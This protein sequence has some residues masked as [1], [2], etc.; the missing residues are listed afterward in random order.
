V[1]EF[2]KTLNAIGFDIAE[3][4]VKACR[5][6]RDPSRGIPHTDI[7]NAKYA[8]YTSAPK[9]L[10]E[11]DSIMVTVP[12]PV[13][14]AHIPNFTYLIAASKSLGRNLKPG[15]KIIFESTVYPGTTEE[16]CIPVIEQESGRKWQRDFCVGYSPERINPGDREY[17]LTKIL[18]LV[19]GDT[20]ETLS[21]VAHLYERIAEPGVYRASSIKIAEDTKV[22]KIYSG[23]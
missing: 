9:L 6:G 18:N 15:A 16:V 2:G 5:E 23:I 13:D 11:A 19:S 12:A 20:P 7:A 8:S 1:V 17:T 4:K 3:E 22:I 14:S 10:R 21:R